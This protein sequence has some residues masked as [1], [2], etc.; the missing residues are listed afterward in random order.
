LKNHRS[1]G[2]FMERGGMVQG[3]LDQLPIVIRSSRSTSFVMLIIGIVFVAASVL[4][5]KSPNQNP[6]LGWLGIAFFGLGVPVFAWR[7]IRPDTLIVAP[8][9][10]TWRYAV[11]TNHWPWSDVQSFRPYSPGGRTISK[12][13]GFDFT[14]SY[15][16]QNRL[17]RSEHTHRRIVKT[18]SG[19]E[20][21]LGGGWELSAADLADL[22]NKARIQWAGAPPSR[23]T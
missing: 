16:A 9:G 17:L 18:I 12:Y 3:S 19:V 2:L 8:D 21:S 7:L 13:L 4:L 20:G 22:L 15:Y 6:A 14:D 11:R 10:I 1:F 5:L 23:G